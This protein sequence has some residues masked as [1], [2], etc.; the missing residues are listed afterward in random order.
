MFSLYQNLTANNL[1]LKLPEHHKLKPNLM[2][3]KNYVVNGVLLRFYL[4]QGLILKMFHRI[5]EFNQ[6][7]CMKDKKYQA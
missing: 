5:L 1:N 4:Q 7:A 3:K 6:E 2:D